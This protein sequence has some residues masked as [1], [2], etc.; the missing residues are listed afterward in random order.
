VGIARELIDSS[1]LLITKRVNWD[2]I[3]DQCAR[4]V[5]PMSDREFLRGTSAGNTREAVEGW[6]SGPRSVDRLNE[7]FDV[8]A[9]VA[10]ERLATG[11][12][13]LAT[14]DNEK[15][16][17]LGI[18]DPLGGYEASDSEQLWLE[19]M[20]DYLF[21]VRYN[22]NC[23][24]QLA[25]S[26]A[27]RAMSVF[28][29][30]V[31]YIEESFGKNGQSDVAIPYRFST[32][33]LSENYL[34]VDGQGELD[35]D[36]RRFRLSARQCAKMFGNGLSSKTMAMANDPRQEHE[37]VELLHYVGYRKERGQSGDPMRNSLVT[38]MYVEVVEQHVIR[39]SGFNFWPI[40][41]YQWNQIPHSP[42]GESPVML[43]LAEIKAGNV[44]AKNS[45]LTVQQWAGPPVATMDDA[46]AGKPNLNARA[47]NYGMLDAQGRLKVQPI[48]NGA[49]PSL[50]KEIQ[51]ASR[52]Q[53][54][55]GLYTNLWQI[56]INNPQMTATEALI[57]ANEKGELLGPIGTKIQ[58][59]LAKATDAE[60]TIVEGKGA[61][62][63]GAALEPPPSLAGR[64]IKA[65][66]DS[67][68]DRLR[69]ANELIGINRTIE[70]IAPLAGAKPELLDNFDGD[71]IVRIAQEVTGMPRRALRTKDE[72]AAMRALRAQQAQ[73]ENTIATVGAAGEA[74]QQAIP[75]AQMAQQMMDGQG[76]A[77]VNTR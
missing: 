19:R 28:G 30:G 37:L 34:T 56:L 7:R 49:N 5:L 6:A 38:S 69:R 43:V 57:R 3:W 60:L 1:N 70:T 74:A 55:E 42:Y 25:N 24:W 26:A 44:I 22:P 14:P 73:I 76:A 65:E 63:P 8:T 50:I 53:I 51:N 40:I 17:G 21:N 59:G 12:L 33:P 4:L 18:S 41:V 52:E 13:S 2:L 62:R 72:V 61:W 31:F 68:L 77:P 27:I 47:I 11:I 39:T 10:A 36:Y 67:P 75:A 23:G 46:S 32:L 35:Q 45:L 16:Q 29:T 9:V 15:W 58:H 54:R 66:F 20:R 48:M 64:S 71:E